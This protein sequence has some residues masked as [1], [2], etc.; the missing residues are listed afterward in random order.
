MASLT[1]LRSG[2]Y[3]QIAKSA[4]A[5]LRKEAEI[6]KG[7]GRYQQF[8]RGFRTWRMDTATGNSCLLLTTDDDWKNPGVE[9]QDCRYVK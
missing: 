7:V 2:E 1:R 9:A 4:L 8:S 3:E 6:G 5:E